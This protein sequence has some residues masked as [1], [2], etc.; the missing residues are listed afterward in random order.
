MNILFR[1]QT[2]LCPVPIV[3]C[4][5]CKSVSF[6]C[7]CKAVTDCF[8]LSG[9]LMAS[10][11]SEEALVNND[12][13]LQYLYFCCL[14]AC[15]D[16]RQRVGLLL[17]RD[18]V[19][20]VRTSNLLTWH[21]CSCSL[22]CSDLSCFVACYSFVSTEVKS[23]PASYV[24]ANVIAGTLTAS[25]EFKK[26]KPQLVT[27]HVN[28]SLV[29][30]LCSHEKSILSRPYKLFNSIRTSLCRLR[31]F[32]PC[33]CESLCFLGKFAICF[34]SFSSSARRTILCFPSCFI[35]WTSFSLTYARSSKLRDESV[36]SWWYS[37]SR[38]VDNVMFCF[39]SSI[40][41]DLF[42]IVARNCFILAS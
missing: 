36:W 15:P 3:L 25:V 23:L 6:V 7:A 13:A 39:P 32:S 19:S 35:T 16:R 30:S 1:P 26:S 38:A 20:L 27:F 29:S 24:D 4:S 34:C 18:F 11:V 12:R 17:R 22:R 5:P 10:R 33:P 37:L 31:S 14:R 41:F 2:P 8:L 40:I 28:V 21:R 42:Q 9:L